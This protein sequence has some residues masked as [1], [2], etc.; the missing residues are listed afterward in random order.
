MGACSIGREFRALALSF[1]AQSCH[2][3]LQ[4][5]YYESLIGTQFGVLVLEFIISVT[6]DPSFSISEPQLMSLY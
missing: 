6:L 1:L 2:R 5:G 3:Y 4:D